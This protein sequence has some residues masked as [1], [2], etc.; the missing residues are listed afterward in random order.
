MEDKIMNCE[1]CNEPTTNKYF[2]EKCVKRFIYDTL[3][4]P[5]TDAK[6]D[7]EKTTLDLILPDLRHDIEKLLE[8]RT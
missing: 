1:L 6:H 7:P 5:R 8:D 4:A 2:C 3:S